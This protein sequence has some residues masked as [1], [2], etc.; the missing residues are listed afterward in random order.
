M[1]TLSAEN[2][3]FIQNYLKNSDV[4][5]IDVRLEMTDHVASAIEEKLNKNPELEF[6]D[7]F[8]T[9]ML[10]HKKELLKSTSKHRWDLDKK[11]LRI[12]GKNMFHP[13]IAGL[14][15]LFLGVF[16][17][18]GFPENSFEFL[19]IPASLISS[20]YILPLI[21]Y[22]Y[23]KIS[24]VHHLVLLVHWINYVIVQL[25]LR[26]NTEN[27]LLFNSIIIITFWFNLSAIK[28]LIESFRYYKTK[29]KKA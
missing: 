28:T 25:F 13:L 27:E 17:I 8:K 11:A 16:Y 20:V 23:L 9:Y 14:F 4:V 21:I 15:F 29:F 7:A 2:I 22:R 24:F 12:I 3:Q 5:F 1:R 10:Q 6:Y 18:V 26:A 19:W